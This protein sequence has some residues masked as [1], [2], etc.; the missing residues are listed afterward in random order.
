MDR[1][2]LLFLN[3]QRGQQQKQREKE[4]I[5]IMTNFDSP[6]RRSVTEAAHYDESVTYSPTSTADSEMIDLGSYRFAKMRSIAVEENRVA[7]NMSR[8]KADSFAQQARFL[9]EEA[10]ATDAVNLLEE[11]LHRACDQAIACRINMAKLQEAEEIKYV[12]FEVKIL[13]LKIWDILLRDPDCRDIYSQEKK[14]RTRPFG[15]FSHLASSVTDWVKLRQ[16]LEWIEKV[17]IM[18]Q[19]DENDPIDDAQ[20]VTKILKRKADAIHRYNRLNDIIFKGE[21]TSDRVDP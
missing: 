16:K 7:R 12:Q 3:R 21:E 6:P 17:L 9:R 13:N 20:K 4:R 10:Q 5:T 1:N 14:Q 18:S 15:S 2:R 8:S 11:S 19:F